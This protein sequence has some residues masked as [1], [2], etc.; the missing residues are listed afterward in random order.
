MH[1]S[2][3]PGHRENYTQSVTDRTRKRDILVKKKDVLRSFSH[4]LP[5]GQ[6]HLN[7]GED[8]VKIAEKSI[9][10]E[11]KR[12]WTEA[13]HSVVGGYIQG[14]TWGKILTNNP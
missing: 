11:I 2:L 9:Y 1:G 6:K 5:S 4:L 12:K 13:C 3:K 10:D 14:W 8:K 7:I